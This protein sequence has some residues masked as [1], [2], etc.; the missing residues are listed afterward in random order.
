M[1]DKLLS[2]LSQD[3]LEILND[4]EFRA[5]MTIFNYR[6]PY[7]RRILPTNKIKNDGTLL[8]IKIIKCFSRNF[9]CNFKVSF[10][11][12]QLNFER[13]EIIKRKN[14]IY[15][16]I[17]G[18]NVSLEEYDVLDLVKIMETA[19]EFGLQEFVNYIQSFL[20]ENKANWM[21]Q[22]FILIYQTSF[23]HDSFSELQNVCTKLITDESEKV[24]NLTLFFF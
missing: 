2:K 21:E 16:Y 20:I 7:L 11:I 1:V 12:Y 14:L 5:H 9:S 10:Y 6:S 17:Y 4:E 3:F 13:S 15:S 22:N 23:K 18:G 8:D 24:F 19:I